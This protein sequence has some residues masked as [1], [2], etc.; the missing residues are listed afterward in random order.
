MKHEMRNNPMPRMTRR[1]I[2]LSAAGAALSAAL[3]RGTRAEGEVAVTR[4]ELAMYMYIPRV[5]DNTESKGRRKIQRQVIR[6]YVEVR[7]PGEDGIEPDISVTGLTN[8]T[9]LVGGKNVTYKCNVIEGETM[10][11][12]IGNNATNVFTRPCVKLS[13]DCD[14]SYNIGAD[15]PDNALIIQ[16]S[17]TGASD[18]R[19]TG[20]VTGQIGCGCHAYGHVSPTRT[21]YGEVDDRVPTYGR[22]AMKKIS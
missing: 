9:H 1:D 5:F 8:K 6:G 10:W 21:R 18:N 2:L 4:Y 15:E 19:I 3:P 17:G 16:L 12:Y 14:P 20:N 13:V 7:D 22:F 11:R